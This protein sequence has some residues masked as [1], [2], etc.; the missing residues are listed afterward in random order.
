VFYEE[1]GG[2]GMGMVFVQDGSQKIGLRKDER[3]DRGNLRDD[4]KRNQKK[5]RTGVIS[6]GT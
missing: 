2:G 1:G 3:H 6:N 5:P 4:P